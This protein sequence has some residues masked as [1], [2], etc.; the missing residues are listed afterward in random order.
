LTLAVTPM[1]L[2]LAAAVKTSA[3]QLLKLKVLSVVPLAK[4]AAHIYIGF[5]CF[6]LAV[7]VLRIR[8][9][10]FKA[11][12]PGLIVSVLMEVPDL[13]DGLASTGQWRWAASLKD[14]V[15]TNLIPIA[16][17]ALFRTGLLRDRGTPK[18]QARGR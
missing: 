15:N 3:Y 1:P 4:D 7:I 18:G 5:A 14:V 13:R 6:L 2:L 17:V 16:L 12:L 10:S 11:V 8:P 9:A